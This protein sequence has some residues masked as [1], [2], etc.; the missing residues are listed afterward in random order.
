MNSNGFKLLGSSSS[1]SS[2]AL[3]SKQLGYKS[4]LFR[5]VSIPENS[6]EDLFDWHSNRS[7]NVDF[8]L[9]ISP[10]IIGIIIP[11]LSLSFI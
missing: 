3:N 9:I 8:V 2:A 5:E 10:V 11:L 6:K 7:E 1:L 4:M